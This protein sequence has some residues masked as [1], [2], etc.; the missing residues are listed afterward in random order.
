MPSDAKKRD[1]QKKK[2]AAKKRQAGIS[3]KR[4]EKFENGEEKAEN[5]EKVELTAE[6]ILCQKLEAEARINA[7]ARWVK[8]AMNVLSTLKWYIFRSCTGTL[9]IHSRSRDIKIENFSVTFY[10]TE[11]L[12]DTTLELN[13]GRRY[14]LVGSNGNFKG[15]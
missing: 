12:Q 14:G 11:I 7:E 5:S 1:Q 10:G 3:A 15:F 8:L 6:E 4:D 9:A 13:C 2:E